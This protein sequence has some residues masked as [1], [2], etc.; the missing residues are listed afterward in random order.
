LWRRPK[1]DS[2]RRVER[3]SDRR[4]PFGNRFFPAGWQ[5]AG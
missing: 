5:D 4:M 2:D 3:G 1:C